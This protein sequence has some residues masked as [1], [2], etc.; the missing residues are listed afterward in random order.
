MFSSVFQKVLRHVFGRPVCGRN[1]SVVQ[2][3]K[4]LA[5]KKVLILFS[6]LR[7]VGARGDQCDGC[8]TLIDAATLIDPKCSICSKPPH[9][10]MLFVC[11]FLFVSFETAEIFSTFVFEFGQVAA[12]SSKVER[13]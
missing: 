3:R 1:L 4:N 2:V 9:K 12:S 7:F 13:R 6:H 8:Q 10:V 11:F 5:G